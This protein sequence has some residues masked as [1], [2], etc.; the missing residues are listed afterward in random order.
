KHT[1][2]EVVETEPHKEQP[3][4]ARPT[5][6]LF[7]PDLLPDVDDHDFTG[8]DSVRSSLNSIDIHYVNHLV[9]LGITNS[10][11]KTSECFKI[12]DT[13]VSKVLMEA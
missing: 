5:F 11:H 12:G 10:R 13:S 1:I 9:G 4:K 6:E 7:E 3:K 8:S 2:Q